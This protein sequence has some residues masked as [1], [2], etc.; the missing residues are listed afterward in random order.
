MV[1]NSITPPLDTNTKTK[2]LDGLDFLKGFAILWVVLEHALPHDVATRFSLVFPLKAVPVFFSITLFLMFRK[3]SEKKHYIRD[4]Y[5]WGRF[6]RM[7]KKV[8][9]PFFIVLIVQLL[10]L[11]LTSGREAL[12]PVI[13]AGGYGPGAYYP[14][15]Y[16]QMWFLAPILFWIVDR[17]KWCGVL[18]LLV[19]CVA[20]NV[21][22]SYVN[23]VPDGLYR[24]LA[25]RYFFLAAIAYI[26]LHSE[27]YNKF[28]LLLLGGASLVYLWFFRGSDLTPIVYN[29]PNW[30]IHNYPGYFFTLVMIVFLL[31]FAKEN[32]DL[33]VMRLF[34]WCGENSWYI[35]LAQMFIMGFFHEDFMKSIIDNSFLAILVYMLIVFALTLGLVYLYLNIVSLYKR[36]KNL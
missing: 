30:T 3:F 23:I 18:L 9:I 6:W 36:K 28:L 29:V 35:F 14:W 32:K 19:V 10:V 12:S 11:L 15:V 33:K 27:D 4:W 1:N 17:K 13:Y 16:L 34:R 21:I 31:A 5:Q 26:W 7:V 25:I 8:F 22:L 2:R 24:L 20:L